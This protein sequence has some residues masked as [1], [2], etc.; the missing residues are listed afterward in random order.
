MR[1]MRMALAT[2]IR[3]VPVSA[4]TAIHMVA[5]PVSARSAKMIL[6]AD[7][8]GDVLDEQA[9]G[10]AGEAHE[11]CDRRDPV[12]HHGNVGGL[13]GAVRAAHAHGDADVGSGKR[14]GVVDAVARHGGEAALLKLLDGLELVLGQQV[15]PDVLETDLF[16]ERAGG[17]LVVACE[18]PRRM[19]TEAS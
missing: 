12:V 1:S 8:E 14:R 15:R 7:G 18:E 6:D 9:V 5:L 11:R 13:D 3:Q 19:P 16:G 10:D 4:K 17:R 2:T